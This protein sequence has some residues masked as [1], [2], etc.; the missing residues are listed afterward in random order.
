MMRRRIV[1]SLE[2]ALFAVVALALTGLTQVPLSEF[3]TALA[4]IPL[5]AA[6]RI[7]A[8]IS[9][10]LGQDGFPAEEL[11]HLIDRLAASPSPSGEKEAILLVLAG[12]LEDGL[13][14]ETLVGKALEGLTRGIA[15]P[16]IEQ[17]LNQRVILLAEVR[18]LL[19]AEGIF[20]VAPGSP[21]TVPTALPTPR[22]DQLVVQIADAVGD[23]LEGGG[24][25]FDGHALYQQVYERLTLLQGV[26]LTKGDVELVLE[27]IEA[28][29]LTQVALKAVS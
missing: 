19:Y 16:T 15:L 14:I 24:S 25:P 26:T 12:A 27:R 2:L 8:A 7:L 4:A 10:G 20:S 28:A 29:D 13:P 22:F 17:G 9:I 18:D 21:Q 1:R 5:A 6:D 23:Y 11:L 3:G